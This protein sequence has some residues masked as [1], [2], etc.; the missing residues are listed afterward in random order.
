MSKE[1]VYYCAMWNRIL[2]C[3]FAKGSWGVVKDGKGFW[4][5][6]YYELIGEL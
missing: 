3:R 4:C 5:G 1:H 2:V 6:G